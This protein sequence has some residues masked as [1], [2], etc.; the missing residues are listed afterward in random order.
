MVDLYDSQ[1]IYPL[2]ILN[3]AMGL[4]TSRFLS[5]PSCGASIGRFYF[6]DSHKHQTG[7]HFF[8]FLHEKE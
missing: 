7:L 4:K 1:V 5:R 2:N 8:D 3:F 6:Y